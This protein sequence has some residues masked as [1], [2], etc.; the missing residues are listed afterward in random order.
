M[1]RYIE[2]IL[3]AE[4][5]RLNHFLCLRV[6]DEKSPLYGGMEW[7]TV[8]PKPVA[9]ALTNALA[10]YLYPESRFYQSRELL[11]VLDQGIDFIAAQQRE[12]GLFDFTICNF[13][14]APDSSFIV[15]PM[16]KAVQLMNRYPR[17]ELSGIREKYLAVLKKAAAGIRD[18]GFHTP[19]HRWAI[20]AALSQL[21]NFFAED[22]AFADSLKKRVARY[23]QEGI[24]GN[25]DGE[26]A[27]RS[28]GNYNEV[29]NMTMLI[30]YEE[31]KDPFFLGFVERNLHM[32]QYYFE[33][34]D[35]I[36]TM[37][38]TRQ[39]Q[40]K[41]MYADQYFMSL[42]QLSEDEN[43]SPENRREFDAAAHKIIRD[44]I[45][46]GAPAPGELAVLLLHD[47][48]MNHVFA[49]E[50]FIREYRKYFRDSGVLRVMRPC[51]TYTVLKDRPDFLYFRV[52]DFELYIKIGESF[53]DVRN[54]VPDRLECLEDGCILRAAKP[55]WY[56]EPWTEK[57]DTSDWWKMDNAAR[58]R[59][60]P[61]N[62]STYLEIREQEDGISLH[63]KTEG[64]DRLPLRFE[65]CVPE[66]TVAENENFRLEALPGQ[67]MI[68][69]KGSVDLKRG[70]RVI[71][72]GDGFGEHSFQG[73]YSD[74]IH[75]ESGMTIYC[76][77][78]TPVDRVLYLQVKR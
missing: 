19:N 64:L 52:N 30:L 21:A 36:F 54:F 6:T 46:R 47:E 44:A 42:L 61:A 12:N 41:S 50:G 48:M 32:M 38:S 17:P 62:L 18:G 76:N 35:T 9:F 58:E 5:G 53:C 33:P 25:E 27:E 24:D 68:L 26:Y 69:R 56:Y 3:Q 16:A 20:S 31:T 7:N 77:A 59:Y 15:H 67:E 11:T 39:D 63:L 71:T 40:G 72:F 70:E 65:L 78:Y 60:I 13:I 37:G 75:H 22:E 1:K 28:T 45:R 66:G 14:S 57:P 34:D 29:V 49:G 8:D 55:D 23:L 10:L 74:E 73:H 43:V 51:Y 2:N 4:E